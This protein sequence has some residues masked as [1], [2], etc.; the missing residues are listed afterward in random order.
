VVGA[1]GF[2]GGVGF[3]GESCFLGW[4]SFFW[5]RF[6]NFVTNSDDLANIII[7]HCRKL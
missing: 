6:L 5:L 4:D 1:A 7:L 3:W 2:W